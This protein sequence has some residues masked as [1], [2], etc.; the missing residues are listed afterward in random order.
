MDIIL[1]GT[2]QLFLLASSK[3]DLHR[4][5]TQLEST[6]MPHIYA[7][8]KPASTPIILSLSHKPTTTADAKTERQRHVDVR[9]V[10]AFGKKMAFFFH[11]EMRS[12]K[13]SVTVDSIVSVSLLIN[14]V[15]MILITPFLEPLNLVAD[16]NNVE[17]E[18][19]GV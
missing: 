1:V 19:P 8:T 12:T 11:A 4:P 3:V 9:L 2:L 6:I 16:L 17:M 14:F 10:S 13:L 7:I 15:V 18:E 5:T